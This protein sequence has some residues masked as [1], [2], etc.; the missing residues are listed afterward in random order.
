MLPPAKPFFIGSLLCVTTG[1]GAWE[2][3]HPLSDR[4]KNKGQQCA[5]C[6]SFRDSFLLAVKAS[7][8][9]LSVRA[10]EMEPPTWWGHES[11]H[12]GQ[13][14]QGKRVLSTKVSRGGGGGAPS[15]HS[16]VENQRS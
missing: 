4:A 13:G 10:I 6:V 14:C 11:M 1:K 7:T 9:R 15:A 5:E 2:W 12:R 3:R 8:R 16:A